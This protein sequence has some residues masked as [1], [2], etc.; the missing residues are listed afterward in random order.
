MHLSVHIMC[1]KMIYFDISKK[2][3]QKLKYCSTTNYKLTIMRNTLLVFICFALIAAGCSSGKNA[4]KKGDYDKAVML[5]VNRLRSDTDNENASATLTQ[6]YKFALD[7]HKRNINNLLASNDPYKWENVMREYKTIN[8]L[9]DEIQK[10]PA[11]LQL[12]PAPENAVNQLNEAKA[13]AAD[14]RYNMALG[15]LQNKNDRSQAIAAHQ[16][17]ERVNQLYPNYMRTNELMDEA[18]FYATLKVVVEPIPAPT[19]VMQLNQEFF[20]NKVN[21]YLH[22]YSVNKYVR[23]YT[24]DEV[25]AQN[26][27]WVDH[28][29]FMSFDQFSLG[30]VISH[31]EVRE[32]K[33]DSVLLSEDDDKKVYGTVKAELKTHSKAILGS[34]LFD[35]KILDANLNKVISQEKFPSEY[36]WE[37]VW[38]TYNGDERALSDEQLELV[39][40]TELSI[41]APQFMFEEFAAPIYDQVIGKIVTYYK[42]Y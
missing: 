26:L 36:R 41:P 39:K 24:P 32:V 18:M 12:V 10:C 22:R 33:K 40:A 13:K 27:D 1:L 42:N 4:L 28:K 21:E 30:N 5:A 38:A 37:I 19:R 15:A 34:G 11:C 23:F 25:R 17:L 7:G 14:V 8:A 6:A 16:H 31:T 35:F 20:Y 9:H 3:V 2:V 29:I